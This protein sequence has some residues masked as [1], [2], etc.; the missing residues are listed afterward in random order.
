MAVV[1]GNFRFMA[2]Q[3]IGLFQIAAVDHIHMMGL[4]P[5]KGIV[6]FGRGETRLDMN[7]QGT[8]PIEFWFLDIRWVIHDYQGKDD[9]YG[10][11]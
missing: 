11:H 8:M 3:A 1:A 4:P 6:S 10:K 5:V 7:R 2:V 9:Q